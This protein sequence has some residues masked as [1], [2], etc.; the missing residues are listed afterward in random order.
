MKYLVGAV[1]GTYD[2]PSGEILEVPF[3]QDSQNV[4]RIAQLYYERKLLKA[5]EVRF[6]TKG[7]LLALQPDDMTTINHADYGGTYDVLADSV[8]INKDCSM[9]FSCIRFS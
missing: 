7:T 2:N 8:K 5:A 4:Q 9:D 3:V 6:T 1:P